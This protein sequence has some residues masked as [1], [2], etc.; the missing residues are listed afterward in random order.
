[1]TFEKID[2][3]EMACNAMENQLETM[4]SERQIAEQRIAT[5]KAEMARREAAR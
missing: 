5:L 1:M 2:R 4:R 3:V